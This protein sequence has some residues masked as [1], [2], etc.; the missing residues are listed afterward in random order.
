M[1]SSIYNQ[2]KFST[3]FICIEILINFFCSIIC[4]G[5][6]YIPSNIYPYRFNLCCILLILFNIINIILKILSLAKY[7]YFQDPKKRILLSKLLPFYMLGTFV[8]IAWIFLTMFIVALIP[9]LTVII[10]S[11]FNYFLKQEKPP[12]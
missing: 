1:E 9:L 6:L 5:F 8:L 3:F 7:Q 12:A 10:N 2:K 4:I 11:K